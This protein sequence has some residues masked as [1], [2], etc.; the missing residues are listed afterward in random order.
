MATISK[1]RMKKLT[2]Q[3]TEM[4]SVI[5]NHLPVVLK[6]IK[7]CFVRVPGE[8]S[9][10]SEKMT[11]LAFEI[12]KSEEVV[13]NKIR[14]DG[15]IEKVAVKLRNFEKDVEKLDEEMWKV[16]NKYKDVG[17]MAHAVEHFHQIAICVKKA[18]QKAANEVINIFNMDISGK[19]LLHGK[20]L[21]TKMKGKRI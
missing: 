6:E 1:H 9:R 10:V 17:L 2:S 12:S 19:E 16:G 18:L 14:S 3:I 15:R 8:V 7:A 20:V 21:G 11:A 4:K 5:K 13:L